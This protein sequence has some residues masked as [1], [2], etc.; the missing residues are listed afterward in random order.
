LFRSVFLLRLRAG[1]RLPRYPA[2]LFFRRGRR[3]I[4]ARLLAKLPFSALLLQASLIREPLFLLAPPLLVLAPLIRKPLL[5][6]VAPFLFVRESLLLV[7]SP[8]LLV[9][10]PFLMVFEALL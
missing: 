9:G 3:P 4:G 8:L 5:K 7:V 1:R 6:V 2:P 10:E